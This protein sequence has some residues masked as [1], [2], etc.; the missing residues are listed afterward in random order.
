[1]TDNI[2]FSTLKYNLY[3]IL[4]VDP[5]TEP[6]KIKKVYL[7]IVKN[8]HPDKNNELEEEIYHHIILANKILSNPE[9]KRSYDDYI[10]NISKLS[11]EL[12]TEFKNN[13][14]DQPKKISESAFT[15]LNNEMN[16]KHGYLDFA[17]TDPI[18]ELNKIKMN[19]ENI[20]I[21]KDDIKSHAEFNGLFEYSK[22]NGKLKTQIIEYKEEQNNEIS[23]YV[24]GGELY[25]S[26]S[27]IDKLYINDSIQTDKFSSLD[28]AFTLQPIM[29]LPIKSIEDNIKEYNQQTDYIKTLFPVKK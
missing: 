13:K 1:M 2:N 18:K 25:T 17:N 10:F 22:K 11:H 8:F 23:T 14:L 9:L 19:R 3:E 5:N 24:S 27:N 6:A 28:R 21:E 4:N 15:E 26:F 29:D 12:K 7:K 20:K 16:K